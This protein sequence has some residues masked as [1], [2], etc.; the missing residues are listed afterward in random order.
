VRAL[1]EFQ[2]ATLA[3]DLDGAR[4]TTRLLED[5]LRRQPA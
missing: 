5:L 4:H 3:V 2:P 1:L